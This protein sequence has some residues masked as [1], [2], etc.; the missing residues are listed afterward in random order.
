MIRGIIVAVS[1]NNVIGVGNRLPWHYPADLKR[2]KRL[3]VGNTI[4]MGRLTF[5][6]IGRVLPDRRSI[7]VTRSPLQTADVETAPS[8]Q[9]AI[10][11]AEES[12][13][14][15]YLW[16]IGGARIF[17]EAM[18]LC[19]LLDVTYVPDT[20]DADGAVFMP[21]IDTGV[22]QAGEAESF[23]DDP[24]LE[25]VVFRRRGVSVRAS[26]NAG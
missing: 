23:P 14:G 25:R 2:F 3:T 22:W 6:S 9:A 15:E 17:A 13:R 5:E 10:A 19:D 21:P 16:F 1:A 18:P 20:I 26:A 7:V 24:R 4:V 8:L 11:L 12:P